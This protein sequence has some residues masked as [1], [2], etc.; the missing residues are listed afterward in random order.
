M[1]F[2]YAIEPEVVA[3]WGDRFNHRF[4]IREFGPGQGRLVS[5][6]PKKWARKV[7]ESFRGGSDLER[8][9]LEEL[10]VRVQETMVKRKDFVWKDGETWLGNALLEH[11]R[12]P[13]R[14]VLA[15]NNP[16]NRPEILVE[17]G[18]A[19]S[20]CQH[21]DTPHGVTVN[22]KAPDISDAVKRMLNCCRWVKFIDPYL[23]QG[24]RGHKES[25]LAFFKILGAERPVG[26]PEA[27]EMHAS[28]EGATTDYL[29]DFYQKITPVGLEVTLYRW[30]ER[31]NGQKLHNR[32]ILTDLGGV[33]FQH[34][35]DTG[36]EGETDDIARLDLAQYVL[37]CK[38]YDPA[39]PAFDQAKA[40]LK[41]I[42]T[43][44]G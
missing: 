29:E 20:P 5:R 16:A 26:P 37:R 24:K 32:Y 33:S 3:T 9:R 42:G 35:L 22:R 19:V 38:Q 18:L 12:H 28:G 40:P 43:R 4:F 41:I 36:R 2:E 13:F 27:I 7:W 10:L 39:A 44:R 14:A 8:K 15:M 31:A 34:G 17:D 25:L 30:Q 1:I 21:W 6:Y 23:V 11:A